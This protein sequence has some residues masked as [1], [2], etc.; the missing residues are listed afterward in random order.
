LT[1][2]YCWQVLSL[3]HIINTYNTFNRP[4]GT[5]KKITLLFSLTFAILVL[6]VVGVYAD[7][8]KYEDSEGR[9]HFVDS[10]EKVP[11]QYKSQVE[12]GNALPEISKVAAPKESSLDTTREQREDGDL[13][14]LNS[15]DS[16]EI[17]V[18]DWCGHC[19]AL[20]K[21]LNDEN[22]SYRRFDIESSEIGKR[23]YNKLGRG[24]I[25][26]TRINGN[27]IVRGNN[28]AKIKHELNK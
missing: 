9:V 19:R 26:I 17:F 24:G 8:I 7:I 27:T 1:S 13:A 4:K 22:I 10:K 15:K 16:L 20:E 25:P 21:A 14:S 3:R 12:S 11:E 28:L 18:A 5:M 6:L 2:N 23:E